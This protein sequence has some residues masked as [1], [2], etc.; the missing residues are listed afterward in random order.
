[1]DNRIFISF[2]IHRINLLHVVR[3]EKRAER[4]GEILRVHFSDGSTHDYE[5]ESIQAI[6]ALLDPI[7]QTYEPPVVEEPVVE[8]SIE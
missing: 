4:H 5:G 6:D 1:M 7:T 3:V 8:E 2:G